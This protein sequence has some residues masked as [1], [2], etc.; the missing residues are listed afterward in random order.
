MTTYRFTIYVETDGEPPVEILG[1]AL[2]AAATAVEATLAQ[3]K[4]HVDVAS[5]AVFHSDKEDR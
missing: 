3:H 1:D 4:G 5:S 2:D